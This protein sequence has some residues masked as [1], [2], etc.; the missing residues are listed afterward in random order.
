MTPIPTVN[1][2]KQEQLQLRF[3]R[4]PTCLDHRS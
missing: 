2:L 1:P 4:A 3:V